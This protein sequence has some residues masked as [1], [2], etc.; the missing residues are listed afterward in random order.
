MNI[1]VCPGFIA[2]PPRRHRGPCQGGGAWIGGWGLGRPG[3]RFHPSGTWEYFFPRKELKNAMMLGHHNN[4]INRT[5]STPFSPQLRSSPHGMEWERGRALGC[6]W[7]PRS[8]GGSKPELCQ[9][10]TA[11]QKQRNAAPPGLANQSELPTPA[12]PLVHLV[13][14]KTPGRDF[15][16][17]PVPWVGLSQPVQG[18]QVQSRAHVKQL[19][20]GHHNW[21]AR[22]LEPSSGDCWSHVPRARVLQQN[23][24]VRSPHTTSSEEPLLAATRESPCTA[25]KTQHSQN[26]KNV[27]EYSLQALPRGD[28]CL[29]GEGTCSPAGLTWRGSVQGRQQ[30]TRRLRAEEQLVTLGGDE[31]TPGRR[32]KW[33]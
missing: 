30:P 8:S 29:Q 19:S 23:T 13:P 28:Q 14:R 24:T 31:A 5:K 6:W 22:D 9:Q 20:L 32:R 2:A 12:P 17:G 7:G 33:T 27:W 3:L 16:G 10:E 21:R 4:Q 1:V 26:T 15:P 11:W 18:A 25:P